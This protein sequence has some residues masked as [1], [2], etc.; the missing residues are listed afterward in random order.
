MRTD[1]EPRV[2]PQL[3][4]DAIQLTVGDAKIAPEVAPFGFG[5]LD[6]P[7]GREVHGRGGR[8]ASHGV[9]VLAGLARRGVDVEPIPVHTNKN[10]TQTV[11]D[12][13]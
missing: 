4:R 11:Q 3:G 12:K 5:L 7:R 8:H 6:V 9:D 13:N 2:E 1:R 10:T